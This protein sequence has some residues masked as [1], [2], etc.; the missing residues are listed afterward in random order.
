MLPLKPP[1]LLLS[2]LLL[3]SLLTVIDTPETESPEES[4]VVMMIASDVVSAAKM[5]WA[6]LVSIVVF[7]GVVEVIVSRT[8]SVSGSHSG[9]VAEMVGCSL[10]LGR[11]YS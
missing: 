11:Q 6:S 8:R 4:F 5:T 1:L 2:L 9:V 3:P 10:G 7:T